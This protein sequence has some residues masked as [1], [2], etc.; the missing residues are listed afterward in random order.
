M[1]PADVDPVA[2]A[3]MREGWGDRRLNLEFMTHNPGSHPFVA[4][5]GG[6]VVGTGLVTLNGP[7]G[8][9]GTIWVEPGWRRRGVGR[10]LTRATIETA[11]DAGCRTLLLVATEVG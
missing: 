9:I 8:W 6:T 2:A 5:D 11:E 7:V 10:A 4:D 3:F 1:T